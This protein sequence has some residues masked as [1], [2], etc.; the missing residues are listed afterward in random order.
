MD[1]DK[2]LLN[3]KI[4]SESRLSSITGVL[5]LSSL[6]TAVLIVLLMY[7]FISG[8]MY[9]FYASALFLF[10]ALVKRMWVS[11]IML[12][13][14]QTILMI[15]LRIIKIQKSDNIKEFQKKVNTYQSE[16]LQL[17]EIKGG[18][19]FGNKILLFYILDFVIQLTTFLTIGRLFLTDF[20]LNNLDPS[21]LY[22]FIPYPIYPIKDVFF[23]IPYPEITKT[24]SLGWKALLLTWGV[25]ILIIIATRA[26]ASAI[27][28]RKQLKVEDSNPYLKQNTKYSV[29]Y[30]FILL[31][32]SWFIVKHFP[33]GIKTGIF[34]GD[35]SKPNKTLNTVTAIMTFLTLMWFGI[36]N[37]IRK[38]KLAK[39]KN[40]DEKT[41]D[42]TQRKMFSQSVF[43]STLVGLGAFFIT[44]HIPSAFELSIFTLEVISLISPFTL[45]KAI[46]KLKN[47]NTNQK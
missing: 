41:I 23:K 24:I 9:R 10:Y 28:K 33:V 21:K 42:Q 1:N 8:G 44:N 15:P 17:K 29:I 38:G 20:Y 27:E 47:K 7:L 31:I 35:V 3:E 18:F 5:P 25:I 13:V 14:L 45:D 37:I 26:V 34:T 6:I 22:K 43:D 36:Q 30:L 16:D 32:I 39:E 4:G 12:G 19:H 11:V 2:K 40:I 46:L